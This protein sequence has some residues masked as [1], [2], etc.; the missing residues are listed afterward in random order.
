[1]KKRWKAWIIVLCFLGGIFYLSS[2]PGLRVLP[3][4]SKIYSIIMR[5]D[6][7]FIRMAEIIAQRLPMDIGE[8]GPFRTVSSDFYTYAQANP[9][10]IEFILRKIAHAMM[11]YFLT[12]AVFFVLNQYTK[13]S[14]TAAC[15]T[16]ILVALFAALDEFRQ[17][18][19]NGRVSS[20]IDVGIDLIGITLAT[21]M[22]MFFISLL[23]KDRLKIKNQEGSAT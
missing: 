13:K 18:F 11:F 20:M 17:S 5:F 8:L 23:Q 3:V 12:I 7:I 6:V 9:G 10:L 2:I 14:M 4:L 1:M 15:I 22:I 16:F 21:L 19:V